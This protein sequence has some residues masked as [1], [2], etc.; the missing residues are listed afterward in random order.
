MGLGRA[1]AATTKV[2]VRVLLASS[3]AAR[4]TNS[5]AHEGPAAL[6]RRD[7][8]RVALVRGRES[9]EKGEAR[10]GGRQGRWKGEARVVS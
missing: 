5:P 10:A 7:A 2:M 3:G 4:Q 6:D 8:A 1:G 9:E